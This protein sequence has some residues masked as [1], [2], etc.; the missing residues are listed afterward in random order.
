MSQGKKKK[1]IIPSDVEQPQPGQVRIGESRPF[2]G[3][4]CFCTVI[5][6]WAQ[7]RTCVVLW[8]FGNGHVRAWSQ[9]DGKQVRSPERLRGDTV[10]SPER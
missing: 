2:L 8:G 3:K 1:T 9:A 5:L 4:R 10:R 7:P 6:L